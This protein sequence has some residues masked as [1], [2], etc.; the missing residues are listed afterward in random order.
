MP[1]IAIIGAGSTVFAR[2]LIGDLLR[3]PALGEGITL[4]LMDVDPERPST[5]GGDGAPGRRGLRRPRQ[6]GGNL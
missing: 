5:L 3:F 6:R 4:A 2:K 1:R